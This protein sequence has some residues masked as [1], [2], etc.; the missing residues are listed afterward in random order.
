MATKQEIA[1]YFSRPTWLGI[2]LIVSPFCIFT[3]SKAFILG[4][5]AIAAEAYII[6]KKLL[7]VIGDDKIEEQY[8]LVAEANFERAIE[9]CGIQKDDLV[10]SPDFFWFVDDF[11]DDIFK[12]TTG[13]PNVLKIRKGVD[14]IYRTNTRG[15]VILNY[16]KDQIF[17]WSIVANIEDNSFSDEN[18]SE[19]FYRDIVGIEVTQNE[20]LTLRTSGGLVEYPLAK[21]VKVSKSKKTARASGDTERAKLVLKALK[22]MIREKKF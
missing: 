1:L 8:R 4:I 15:I 12:K 11:R 21:D 20:V 13:K 9:D 18:T 2:A 17:S 14:G 7:G 16:G 19:F 10:Q 5:L 22:Q 3:F 6:K